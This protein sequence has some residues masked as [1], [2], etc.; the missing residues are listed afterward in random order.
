MKK[1]YFSVFIFSVFFSSLAQAQL[2]ATKDAQNLVIVKVI[3][4]YKI[5]D[6]EYAKDIESLRSSER[7]NQKLQRMLERLSNERSK[8][9][10]NRQII[11][12]LEKAGND[13]DKVLNIR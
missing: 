8:D 11:K 3:A 4:D 13:I 9:S 10:K 6:A 2:S 12:I 5:D 1:L 7:F